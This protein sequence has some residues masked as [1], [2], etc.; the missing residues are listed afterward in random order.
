MLQANGT[1][2]NRGVLGP[3]GMWLFRG[4]ISSGVIT[5]DSRDLKAIAYI[6]VRADQLQASAND[7]SSSAH[8][9]LGSGSIGY[10]VSATGRF[11]T[12]SAT[13]TVSTSF[14]GSAATPSGWTGDAGS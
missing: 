12:T 7:G 3:S 6:E 11:S 9:L 5:I 10:V 1:R 8:S 14:G 13:V 2:I 4:T